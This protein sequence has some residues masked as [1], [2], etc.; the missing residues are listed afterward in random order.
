M[1][2]VRLFRSETEFYEARSSFEKMNTNDK[3]GLNTEEDSEKCSKQIVHKK[4]FSRRQGPWIQQV[5]REGL[6]GK[7]GTDMEDL[8]SICI[9]SKNRQLIL[10]TTINSL[11]SMVDTAKSDEILKVKKGLSRIV[12]KFPFPK[13]R[14]QKKKTW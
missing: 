8:L 7:K 9:F 3:K 13:L 10:Y 1:H 2:F 12:I 6:V 11:D 14:K 4:N 5:K